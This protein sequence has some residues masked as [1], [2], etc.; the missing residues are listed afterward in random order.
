MHPKNAKKNTPIFCCFC[1]CARK[2]I[3][4]AWKL[5]SYN[6]FPSSTRRSTNTGDCRPAFVYRHVYRPL[7]LRASIGDRSRLELTLKHNR[8]FLELPGPLT[9]M[10]HTPPARAVRA[11]VAW[12]SAGS[13][14]ARA[15]EARRTAAA[16]H[17]RCARVCRDGGGCGGCGAMASS[18]S[19]ARAAP[20]T[21]SRS[22]RSCALALS[23]TSI[24][25]F[26]AASS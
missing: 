12:P 17:H 10:P 1:A 6:S 4:R 26:V 11:Y 24:T 7:L 9:Y 23:T 3:R 8:G 22:R 2:L 14:N 5:I 20:T 15:P 19:S 13:G 25:T 18:R 21:L 16:L